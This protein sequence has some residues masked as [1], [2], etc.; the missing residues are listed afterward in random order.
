M[1]APKRWAAASKG[2]HRASRSLAAIERRRQVALARQAE[3][4]EVQD[5]APT[6]ARLLPRPEKRPSER[7]PPPPPRAVE[8]APRGSKIKVHVPSWVRVATTE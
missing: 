8:P 5:L 3:A 4:D 7:S 6:K 2:T 1:P